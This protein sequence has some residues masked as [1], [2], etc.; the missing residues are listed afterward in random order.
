MGL[1]T[2]FSVPRGGFLYT[3][4]VPWG[5]FLLPSSRV[6][7]GMVVDEIDTCIK[8]LNVISLDKKVKHLNRGNL[9]I[10]DTFLGLNGVRYREV[11]L[12]YA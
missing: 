8:D 3:M 7:G 4:I 9:L 12:Y 6:P 5:R 11:S 1:L 10:A 2:P